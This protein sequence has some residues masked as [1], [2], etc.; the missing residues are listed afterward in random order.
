MPLT[1]Y[2]QQQ[3][4]QYPFGKS[5]T[6]TVN[7][8][9]FY[10]GLITV[11]LVWTPSTAVTVGQYAVSTA[12][13]TT[14]RSIWKCTA[15]AGTGTT[16]SGSDPLTTTGAVGAT[17]TDNAGA[18]QVVWTECTN[19]F[20]LTSGTSPYAFSGLEPI[21]GT[22]GY[23]RGAVTNTQSGST[24]ST[25]TVSS[26]TAAAGTTVSYQAALSFGASTGR[27]AATSH[28]TSG[29]IVGYVLF[30]ASTAGNAWAFG[31]LTTYLSVLSSGITVSVASG[32]LQVTLS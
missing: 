4:V 6:Q 22:N 26:G 21:V 20:F 31:L 7:P 1:N 13:N 17:I 25:P 3:I 5:G 15:V 19:L 9:S 28:S 8:T 18:N 11:D 29:W 12:F 10:A 30:D 32:Q 16:G 27:W 24:W 23:A 2:G 14:G